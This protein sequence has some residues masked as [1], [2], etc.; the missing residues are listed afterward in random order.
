MADMYVGNKRVKGLSVG[1]SYFPIGRNPDNAAIGF[2]G[3]YITIPDGTTSIAANAFQGL[4]VKVVRIPASVTSIG[5]RAFYQCE[6]DR[7]YFEGDPPTLDGT[8]VFEGNDKIIMYHKADNLKWTDEIKSLFVSSVAISL[9]FNTKNG[10][11]WET[12]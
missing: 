10:V 1:S 9:G 12:Y 8:E 7:V 2:T 5:S 4:A 11:I 6:L 3:F